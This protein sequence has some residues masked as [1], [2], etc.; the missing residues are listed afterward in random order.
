DP[1][2]ATQVEATLERVVAV[3]RERVADLL[4]KQVRR[5]VATGAAASLD[6]HEPA[7]LRRQAVIARVPCRAQGE[8][9]EATIVDQW[10]GAPRLVAAEDRERIDSGER[11]LARDSDRAVDTQHRCGLPLHERSRTAG[12]IPVAIV[13]TEEQRPD[14]R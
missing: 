2:V 4:G 13:T 7:L 3:G 14:R 6:P 10:I 8:R 9:G 1:L 11:T 12:T 5:E